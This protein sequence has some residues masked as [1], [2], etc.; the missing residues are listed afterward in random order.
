[1]ITI[2]GNTT[3]KGNV[4]SILSPTFPYNGIDAYWTFNN[5][6]ADSLGGPTWSASGTLSYSSIAVFTKSLYAGSGTTVL[7]NSSNGPAFYL[8]STTQRTYNYWVNF[9]SAGTFQFI[10]RNTISNDTFQFYPI[11]TNP[12]NGLNMTWNYSS[13]V[14]T[15]W[16]MITLSI[17]WSGTTPA[18]GVSFYLNGVKQS[19][20]VSADTLGESIDNTGG[21]GITIPN[22]C[23]FDEFGFWNRVLSQGEI[24]SLYNNGLGRPY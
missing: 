10:K 12:A 13:R 6:L 15:G 11:S 1:M 17:N 16:N 24:T 14:G 9:A 19:G 2:K 8:S 20:T 23:R 22:N 4:T 5:T 3:I 18:S 7:A 21:S